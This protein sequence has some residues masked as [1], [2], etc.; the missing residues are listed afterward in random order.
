MNEACLV[1]QAA[2]RDGIC[3]DSQHMKVVKAVHLQPDASMHSLLKQTSGHSRIYSK[4]SQRVS[5]LVCQSQSSEMQSNAIM[6]KDAALQSA[7]LDCQ[8][9]ARSKP[10][11]P[12]DW[13]L[14][15][16]ACCSIDM[17]LS[18]GKHK[19][20]HCSLHQ[21]AATR[22]LP[23]RI[24]ARTK[25]KQAASRYCSSLACALL[26]CNLLHCHAHTLVRDVHEGSVAS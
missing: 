6:S 12:S 5:S 3:A 4:Q 9:N 13:C 17:M 14:Q 2:L 21:A 15:T 16:S 19:V 18:V 22:W 20:L 1:Q 24:A 7:T 10:M 26:F 25:A 11:Q 8:A 23:E